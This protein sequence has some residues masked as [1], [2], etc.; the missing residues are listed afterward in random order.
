MNIQKR[1]LGFL[2]LVVLFAASGCVKDDFDA[3]DNGG[4][5]D[6][7][8]TANITIAALKSRYTSGNLKITDSLIIEGVVISSDQEGNFY[9]EMVIQDATGGIL[10]LIDQTNMYTDFPVGRKVYVNMLNLYLSNYGGL[11]QVGASIN[12]DDNSLERIP[13]SLVADFIKKGPCNQELVPLE[14]AVG[15]LDPVVHQSRL[16]KLTSVKMADNDANV[17]WATVGGSSAKN[18]TIADCNNTAIIARTSDF[19]RFAG[20]LTPTQRFDI[21]GVFSIFNSD[22]QLKLRDV[23]KD[24]VVT[25]AACACIE[26][27]G[28]INATTRF[29]VDDVRIFDSSQDL[30]TQNFTGVSGTLS[31]PGWKNIT[32]TG[33]LAWIGG[34]FNGN[35][36]AQISAFNSGQPEITTWLIAPAVT[37]AGNG[38]TLTFTTQ[39]AYDDGARLEVLISTDYDGGNNPENFTWTK[40]CPNIAG[41]DANSFG[42]SFVPSG[43]VDLTPFAGTTYVAWRYKAGE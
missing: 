30:L 21:T 12:A 37:V 15:D 13:Q 7:G 41:G 8:L 17:S 35:G 39:D 3:P 18:R 36:Y 16:I 6:E 25:G 32:Q 10:L 14:V 26:S 43:N 27:V 28:P 4:C 24:V 38:E 33:S 19:A 1:I 9:K 11:I 42:A 29:H 31:L 2:M 22:K 23:A 5:I 20:T 40:V 34:N